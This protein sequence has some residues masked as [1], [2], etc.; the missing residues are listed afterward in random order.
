M[1]IDLG[2]RKYRCPAAFRRSTEYGQPQQGLCPYEVAEGLTSSVIGRRLVILCGRSFT[3]GR[4]YSVGVIALTLSPSVSHWQHGAY[5]PCL[6]Y[7][8]LHPYRH[9]MFIHLH[10]PVGL[11]WMSPD[12]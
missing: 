12:I 5:D 6:V 8:V 9:P 10:P 3:L 7:N 2:E 1:R 11:G 4:A